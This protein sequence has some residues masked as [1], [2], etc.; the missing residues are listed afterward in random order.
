MV[1]RINGEKCDKEGFKKVATT[2]EA[3]KNKKKKKPREESC[4]VVELLQA[5]L[6]LTRMYKLV[7]CMVRDVCIITTLI[8][9]KRRKFGGV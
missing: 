3:K 7:I 9:A 8:Q 6:V 4:G 5:M 2:T 1:Q